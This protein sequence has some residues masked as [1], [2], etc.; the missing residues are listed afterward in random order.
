MKSSLKTLTKSVFPSY[1]AAIELATD[2]FAPLRRQPTTW[3]LAAVQ[4][5]QL[6]LHAIKV[7]YPQYLY[8]L[9]SAARTAQAAGEKRFTAIEF[10]VAGGNGLVA[11]EKHAEMVE[12]KWD[13]SID[14]VGF[15][16]LVGLPVRQ[17]PRDCQFGLP[18]GAFAMDE[19]KL[20]SRLTRAKLFLGDIAKTIDSFSSQDFAPIGFVSHDFDLYTSTRDSLV[21]FQLEPQRMLPRI[22]MYFDDLL[23]YPYSTVTG[24]WA[25][26]NEFNAQSKERQIGQLY[27]VRHCLGRHYRFAA[28]TDLLFML[29]IFDHPAYNKPEAT[30][31]PD[32]NLR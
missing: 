24:E 16:N 9:L 7:G 21:L 3:D 19:A 29:H 18:E 6:R 28:W 2:I 32:L 1:T 10:G 27:G 22:N 5:D 15:D 4:L 26:I 13:V 14:I 20:R 25:A 17:D 12:Q 8:G 23:G 31:M 30:T 11:M